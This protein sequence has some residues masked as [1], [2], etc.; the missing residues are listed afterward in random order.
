MPHMHQ[1]SFED[2]V[3]EL[4][5]LLL[6]IKPLQASLKAYAEFMAYAMGIPPKFYTATFTADISRVFNIKQELV[7]QVLLSGKGVAV[8]DFDSLVPKQGWI[9]T[10][11][12]YTRQT[13][14]P[15]VF[16]FFAGLNVLGA[17]IGRKIKFPRGSGDLFPNLNVVLVSPPG[18]CK[19]TTACNLAVKHYQKL[20]MNLMADKVTPEA[21]VGALQ[22][23]AQGLIYAPEW[24]VF[25]GKQQYNEGLVP[26]LTALFDCPDIWESRTIARG[27]VQ[28]KDVAISHL[29]CTT[30][31]WMQTS[32]T[33]DAFAGGFMSRLLFIVQHDSPRKFALPP[34][35]DPVLEAKLIAD[36]LKLQHVKGDI[37]LTQDA[38]AWYVNWYNNRSHLMVD[39]HFAGYFER[40]P[41]RLLQLAILL[42][43]SAT[44]TGLTLDKATLE[45]SERILTWIEHFLPSAFAE[46]SATIAGDEQGRI[47]RQIRSHGEL[48]YSVW[49]RMNTGRLSTDTFKKYVETL[50]QS[51]LIA[52]DHTRHRYYI[53]PAGEAVQ[54]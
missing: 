20:G 31:D 36:L 27:V 26:M 41:D 44:I 11:I 10:H 29:A 15:T 17:V 54:V 19:K 6:Q 3:S 7:E 4:V 53:L 24:A 5:K 43:T 35:K 12:E 34:P 37:K 52:V 16:H 25:L 1:L 2:Q 9:A 49:L 14:P 32:I 8:I 50:K 18:K 23:N 46:M 51:K 39:K 45:H 47:L 22:V 13:E 30:I 33:K 40:K 28:L 42:N 21:I 48:D 38:E